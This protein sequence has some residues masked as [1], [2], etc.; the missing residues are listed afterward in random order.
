MIKLTYTESLAFKKMGFKDKTDGYFVKKMPVE[1]CSPDKWNNKGDDYVAMLN[2]YQAVEFLSAKKGIH[3][4][5]SVYQNTG[6]YRIELIT[7]IVHTRNGRIT[8]QYELGRDSM[9]M[10]F[11]LYAGVKEVLKTLN[12]L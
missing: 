6:I 9:T 12:K 5:V 8:Y 7:T 2:V 1:F 10:K 4:C 3:I 11:A